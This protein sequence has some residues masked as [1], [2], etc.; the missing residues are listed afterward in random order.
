MRRVLPNRYRRYRRLR[1]AAVGPAIIVATPSLAGER[2]L[3]DPWFDVDWSV[4]LRGAYQTGSGGAHSEIL[5]T[6]E[7]S[8]THKGVTDEL[9]LRA[10]AALAADGFTSYRPEDAHVG[11][12]GKFNI[13]ALTTLDGSVN[14]SLKRLPPYDSSLPAN[15]ATAPL[16]VTG[17]AAGSATRKFGQF[18]LTGRLEGE[19]FLRGETTLTDAST[20]DNSSDSYWSGLA[21]LRLGY[22]L[23]PLLSVFVDASEAAK[24]FDAP[25]PSVL[26]YLDGRTTTLRAGVSYTQNSVLSMEA[27]VGRAWIDYVDPGLT[28]APS[29]VYDASL[30]FAP[31]ETVSLNGA[32]STTL[33]PS[34]DTPGDTDVTYA[35]TGSASY[36]VN[37]WITL[38]GSGSWDQV[39]T[40]GTGDVGTGYSFGAGMDFASSKHA[41]WSADYLFA[42]D[43]TP[44]GP[45]TDTQTVTVGVKI[46]R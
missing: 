25:S 43:Y 20:I 40:L 24:K 12:Y 19:R 22:E 7:V 35:L 15:T 9:T 17:T 16:E 29:W 28:D 26:A 18:D 10:G 41:E 39:L 44:P 3:I 27:S 30:T 2:V 8:L 37:P 46:K 1:S 21:G 13:D 6:P 4:G 33:G 34:D 42:H 32:L 23:T 38:R 11:A 36:K 14:L 31:D 45:A 5:V